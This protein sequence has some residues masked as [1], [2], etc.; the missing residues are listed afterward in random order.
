MDVINDLLSFNNLKIIQN[1]N[2]LSFSLD[3]VLLVNFVSLSNKNK[4]I[5]DIGCGNAPIPLMLS[6]V[7]NALITGV[8]IQEDVYKLALRSVDLNNLNSKI[9]LLNIDVMEFK[10]LYKQESFDVIVSNPPFFKIYDS[11]LLNNSDYKTIARHE[12]FLTLDNLFYISNY[13]LKTG[14]NI[15]IVHRSD[16]LMDI[17]RAM[18]SNNIEPKRLRFVYPK[19]GSESNIV[20]IEG[21]KGGKC[22]LKVL[23]PLYIHNDDGDYLPEIKKIF[24]NSK[25]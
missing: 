5:L 9:K 22:G 8:E 15:A 4:N 1:T 24:G 11:S 7:S 2:M 21:I 20:L 12:L 3:S 6:T 17:I 18:I 23:N 14:G 10:K 16:R 19:V 25:E 13:L